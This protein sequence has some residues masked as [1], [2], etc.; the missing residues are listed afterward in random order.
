MST[1]A[2]AP[3]S[4]CGGSL[5]YK[6]VLDGSHRHLQDCITVLRERLADFPVS[7]ERL[8]QIADYFAGLDADNPAAEIRKIAEW[9]RR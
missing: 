4:R 9:R 1:D 3:C 7:A 2:S 8:R 5:I 6:N